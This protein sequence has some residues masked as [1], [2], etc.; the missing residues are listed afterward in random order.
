MQ[1]NN[2]ITWVPVFL[3][4]HFPGYS[5]SSASCLF[6]SMA[7]FAYKTES[8]NWICTQPSDK[9]K[10]FHEFFHLLLH[11][12]SIMHYIIHSIMHSIIHYISF[13]P[14]LTKTE[15]QSFLTFKPRQYNC[16][17]KKTNLNSWCPKFIE[18]ILSFL[19]IFLNFILYLIYIESIVEIF[20][21][22][23]LLT[24]INEMPS[25]FLLM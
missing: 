5:T 21:C 24:T 19:S 9:K 22:L 17:Q 6:I 7:L 3:A 4:P 1:W 12:L 25:V 8:P 11:L 2:S 14:S 23:K 16:D 10:V 13:I 15:F 18:K 20:F